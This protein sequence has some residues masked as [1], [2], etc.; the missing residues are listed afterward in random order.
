[1]MADFL[2][3]LRTEE[4]PANALPGARRQ[5][6]ERLAAAL[7]ENGFED[8]RV[9][10]LSTN[11]R[12]VVTVPGLPARQPDR[13]E[14]VM[15]PP[16]RVAF[17]A[18]GRPTKAAEGFARKVGLPVDEL[19]RVTTDKGEYLAAVVRH[20]GRPTG[21]ILAEIVPAVVQGL[22]F[23]K[24]MRWGLGR[25]TFVR[26]LHGVVALLDG[27]VV[28]LELFGIT[29]GRTTVGHRVHAPGAIE[30]E[31][32][33]SYAEALAARH[34]I[35]DPAERRRM[36]EEQ[37]ERLAAEAGCRVHPD[38]R[39][40][41]EHVEL[42]EYPG[43]IRGRFD[44]AFLELPPEVVV[45]TLRHHQKCLILETPDGELSPHFLAVI[46]RMDD[47]E[48]LIRQGNEWVIGARLADA[49]FFFEEDGKR[50]LAELV[51]ELDRL[52]FHRVLGSLGEKVRRSGRIAAWLGE[53]LGSPATPADLER[54][55]ALV[56]A[57]LVTNM[58]GEFPELQGI[59][60]GHYLR[61]DGEPEEIWTAA[62]D[63]YRPTGFEGE[64]PASEIG[65]IVGVA[66]R[67]DT[68]TGLFAVGEVPTGSRDPFGL[69]RAAQAV[70]RIIAESGWE[71]DLAEAVTV[72]AEGVAGTVDAD[73][74]E[75]AR[76]VL[77]FMEDR[78]RRYLVDRT[79]V[80][81]DTA[82]AVMAAGWTRL[83]GLVVRAVALER[84]RR[85][86]AFRSLALAFKR[87]RNITEGQP[88]GAVDPA[89]FEQEAET[90]LHREATAFH[91]ILERE[92]AEGRVD[93]AFAAMGRLAGVLETFF[94]DVLVMAEDEALRTNRIALLKALGRDFL[95][96]AD[97]SRL[98]V[99]GSEQ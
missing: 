60:G 38:E 8:V 56:K 95:K 71:L 89:L 68:L 6:E 99:E 88:D 51:P 82:D 50:R 81:G 78:V 34:V 47:P 4:I 44:E 66:D 84:A 27:E 30:L 16:A 20:E 3:E 37:A 17:D 25:Y 36:L 14:R 58:V 49:R 24:T 12:L 23:P 21:E 98:Q 59:M 46:D 70:V 39:L 48:E 69:R 96:L 92:L 41:A 22:H 35:I 91:E 79:G 55:A 42:V 29:A 75:V 45:T 9:G 86:A 31:D 18:D 77:D 32:A 40:V 11:R 97:L 65:R 7:A 26:P 74:G 73:A 1:M 85:D 61:R 43:L 76:R 83:P 10:C 93:E 90:A 87:V 19:E 13:E 62:R 80:A 54:T 2:L 64:L 72:A 52:E 53:A 94:V 63:H 15:G 67:L 33:A 57:D 28:P 5:L